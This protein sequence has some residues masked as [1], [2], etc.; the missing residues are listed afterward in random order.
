[1]DLVAD[2]GATNARFQ[3]CRQ[4]DLQGQTVTLPTADFA[5]A[6]Q[7]LQAAIAAL[8]GETPQR[9]LLAVAG[10]AHRV[11]QI[12]I[13]NTGLVLDAQRCSTVLGCTARLANDFFAL[14]HG[15]P[16]FAQ[17]HQLGGGAPQGSTKALLGPGTGLGMATV[18]RTGASADDSWLVIAS[19]GGHA[20]LA[21]GTHLEAEL[22]GVLMEHHHHV[23]WETVLSGQGLVRLYKAMCTVWGMR[24]GELTPA[25]ITEQG[26]DMADPVCHQTLETFCALLGA[27]AANLAV[28]VAAT[29]G[30]YIGGGIVTRMLDFVDASAL[31]RRFDER[32]LMS[33]FV[34]QIPILVI[35]DQE[36]GLIGA[37]RCLHARGC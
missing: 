25:D 33:D 14:A 32:G 37:A 12:Q 31:R 13:T 18:A 21:P 30:V 29:G 4:G 19:E 26:Q 36:P 1:M 15:V 20:D 10:P 2:I 23:C 24:P 5:D 8:A 28:T 6:E 35:L 3:Y 7:L 17:L 22:W 11:D 34:K 27:A 16:Y 9:A